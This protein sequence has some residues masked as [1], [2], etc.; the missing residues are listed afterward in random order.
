[1][2]GNQETLF[3]NSNLAFLTQ[4]S[5]V[6]GTTLSLKFGIP[7]HYELTSIRYDDADIGMDIF[8]CLI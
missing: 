8:F 7:A 1:M 3:G 5:T 4:Q 2:C 6:E